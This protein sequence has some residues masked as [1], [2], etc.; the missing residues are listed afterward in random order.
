MGLPDTVVYG[1]CHPALYL[2][3]YIYV[4]SSSFKYTAPPYCSRAKAPFGYPLP[5]ALLCLLAAHSCSPMLPHTPSMPPLCCLC[6]PFV[7][8]CAPSMLL[9][10]RPC[11]FP[12]QNGD[13]QSGEQSEVST[14]YFDLNLNLNYSGQSV[15]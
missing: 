8:P 12:T 4:V 15:I 3:I 10:K 6:A 1:R 5:H 14:H 9:L 7:L 11:S 2:H 13:P